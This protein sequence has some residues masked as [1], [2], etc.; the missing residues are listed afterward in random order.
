MGKCVD[1]PYD[2]EFN[3]LKFLIIL[4]LHHEGSR[5][6]QEENIEDDDYDDYNFFSKQI[7]KIIL[8]FPFIYTQI[9]NIIFLGTTSSIYFDFNTIII[10]N[11][12]YEQKKVAINC[13][14]LVSCPVLIPS[15]TRQHFLGYRLLTCQSRSKSRW[16]K[17]G[18]HEGGDW[19]MTIILM[20]WH[21]KLA[22]VWVRATA[23]TWV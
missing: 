5:Y 11:Y 8:L 22:Y 19:F 17:I 18:Q 23:T 20:F 4:L 14:R 7:N 16:L 21:R 9:K 1:F 15:F 12:N 13:W 3:N 6:G 2:D 10:T